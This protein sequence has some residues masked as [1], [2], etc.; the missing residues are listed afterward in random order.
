MVKIFTCFQQDSLETHF[1]CLF[2]H[3]IHGQSLKS[4]DLKITLE[5]QLH[6]FLFKS[7]GKDLEIGSVAEP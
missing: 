7:V 6:F 4:I 5:L 3:F 1:F 2:N